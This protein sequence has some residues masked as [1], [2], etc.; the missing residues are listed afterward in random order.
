MFKKT[1][2]YSVCRYPIIQ[3]MI[4]MEAARLKKVN[5]MAEKT[6]AIVVD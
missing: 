1:L 3:I 6:G 2:F 5:D 4:E